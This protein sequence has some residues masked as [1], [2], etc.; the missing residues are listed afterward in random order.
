MFS[1]T[2]PPQESPVASSELFLGP[3]QVLISALP[4]EQRATFNHIIKAQTHQKGDPGVQCQG[5][6]PVNHLKRILLRRLKG[7]E[8]RWAPMVR[9][10]PASCLFQI[11]SQYLFTDHWPQESACTAPSTQAAWHALQRQWAVSDSIWHQCYLLQKHGGKQAGKGSLRKTHKPS[12]PL[13]RSG[14][15]WRTWLSQTQTCTCVCMGMRVC[16]WAHRCAPYNWLWRYQH[17]LLW[18]SV[19]PRP[20]TCHSEEDTL[21][22]LTLVVWRF[23]LKSLWRRKSI[24]SHFL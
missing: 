10:W 7:S 2:P 17:L 24:Q 18:A 19:H 3:Y 22:V 23:S 21:G 9:N 1:S 16:A 11:Q 20:Y 4:S 12:S 6:R 14:F 15:C 13:C 8:Q 5:S